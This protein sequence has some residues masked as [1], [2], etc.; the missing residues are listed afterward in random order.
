MIQIQLRMIVKNNQNLITKN[1]Q[2]INKYF[3]AELERQADII[4]VLFQKECEKWLAQNLK[5]KLLILGEA[6]LSS[7]KYF[8]NKNTGTYLS[9]LKQHYTEAKSLKDSDYR[10]FLREKGI[11]SL[12][13]YRFPLPTEFYDNDKK[14]ILFDREFISAKIKRLID[15]KII[16]DQTIFTYRYKKLIERGIPNLDPFCQINFPHIIDQPIAIKANA[17][18][19]NPELIKYLP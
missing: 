16:T 17:G 10:N 15:M 13:I 1:M 19:L 12:D 11:L 18:N 8:Y 7:K 4:D 3:I 5:C 14:L 9:F 2:N 6:P